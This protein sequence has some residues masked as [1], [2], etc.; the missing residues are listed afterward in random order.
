[1]KPNKLLD[2]IGTIILA[3]GMLIAFSSHAFHARIGLGEETSHLAHEIYG[4][5]GVVIGLG[6]LIYNNK[7]F[8]FQK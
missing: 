1:M 3:A 6:I 2:V 7:A 4:M 8:K 5:I